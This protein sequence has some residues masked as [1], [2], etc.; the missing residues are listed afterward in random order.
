METNEITILMEFYEGQK[1]ACIVN[2]TDMNTQ[3]IKDLIELEAFLGRDRW[4]I[5]RG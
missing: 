1:L 4:K 2:V 5:R 3:E